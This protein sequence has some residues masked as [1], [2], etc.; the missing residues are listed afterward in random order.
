[1][2]FASSES[3]NTQ[4]GLEKALELLQMSNRDDVE[5]VVLVLTDGK[6]SAAPLNTELTQV[7]SSHQPCAHTYNAPRCFVLMLTIM[8]SFVAH[9][10]LVTVILYSYD[11]AIRYQH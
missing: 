8:R 1:M 3:T 7:V 5:E 2:H 4:G 11:S 9:A 6:P 10:N